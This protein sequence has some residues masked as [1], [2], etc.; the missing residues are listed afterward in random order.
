M[1]PVTAFGLFS[2][3]IQVLQ[4]IASTVGGLRQLT[5]KLRE[6]DFTIQSL[7]QELACIRTALTSL[8]E[9]LRIHRNGNGRDGTKFDELDQDLAV[10]MDGCRVIME[11]LSYEVFELVQSAEESGAINFKTRMKIVWNEDTMRGHQEKLRAQVQAL[12]LLLQVCQWW[13]C[14]TLIVVFVCKL[15]VAAIPQRSKSVC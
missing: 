6:A 7:I 11:V 3:A 1:D 12:Q 8:K 5:G 15:T 10:A 2:G 13:E 9:W 14:T 4:A